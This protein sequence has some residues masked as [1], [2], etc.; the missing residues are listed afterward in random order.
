MKHQ[1]RVKSR[2]YML[3]AIIDLRTTMD[4]FYSMARLGLFRFAFV[5]IC[6]LSSLLSYLLSW[7]VLIFI[8]ILGFNEASVRFPYTYSKYR[9]R[10]LYCSRSSL[11][12]GL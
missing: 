4:L 9:A 6:F 12:G 8:F 7:L 3:Y 10:Y 11:S 2:V 1:A 5:E